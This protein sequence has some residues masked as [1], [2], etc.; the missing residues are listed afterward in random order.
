MDNFPLPNSAD[1]VPS[2]IHSLILSDQQVEKQKVC[3][4]PVWES[5]TRVWE[6]G[7]HCVP[8]QTFQLLF[9]AKGKFKH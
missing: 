8:S 6:S 9:K 4:A 5:G 1:G 7:M 3:L 2:W